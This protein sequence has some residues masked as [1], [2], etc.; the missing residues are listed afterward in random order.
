M[1]LFPIPLF[2]LKIW[3]AML[4]I[5]LLGIDKLTFFKRKFAMDN[6]GLIFVVVWQ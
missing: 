4:G 5:S 1:L 6:S 2:T 3:F